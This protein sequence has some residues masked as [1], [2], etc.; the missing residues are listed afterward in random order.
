MTDSTRFAKVLK[1]PEVI[2]LA[3]GAMIGWSWVLLTGVWLTAAGTI[4]T[5]IAFCVG[6]LAVTLIG[7]TYSELASAMPKAGGEHIY[8]ERALGSRWSFVCTWALLFSYVNVC[9]FEAVALPSAVEYLFPDIRLGTLWNVLG[10]DVDLGFILIGIG[11]TALVTWVNYLGIRTA[12]ILQA[13]VTGLIVITGVLLIS[14]AI[15]FGEASNA[16]PWI[17]TPVSGILIVLIMVPSMLIGF[18]V[19]PQSAEEIDLPPNKI[20]RLLI[21]SVACAVAWYIAIAMAVGFGLNADALATTKMAT[22]D[23]ASALWSS[24]WAGSLLVL[25]GIGGILTSW[26]AFII[27]ASRVLFALAE[28]GH[29]PK[30]FAKLHPKYKTPYVGILAIG[31]LTMVAPLFGRTI[32]VWLVNSGS[33]AVTVAFVFVALSFLVLRKT[34]PDMPRPFKV[35]HPNLVGYGGV[36][37]S[38]GLLSAFFPWSASALAWPEEWMTILVWSVIGALLLLRYERNKSSN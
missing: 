5:L 28:S 19:I 38:L 32:L 14:G 31:A 16:Q 34:E 13:V 23:A 4:G 21:F 12:A 11:A 36:I 8:T 29:V 3:F 26:N 17:A 6:G 33:F 2:A 24:S 10:S 37:M 18:D 15:A 25:G 1:T 30:V 9:M 20:G 27:G 7:L 22:A 35:S